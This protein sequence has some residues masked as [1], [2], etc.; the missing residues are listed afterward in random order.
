MNFFKLRV[1]TLCLSFSVLFCGVGQAFLRVGTAKDIITP[2]SLD[3]K[4]VGVFGE[5]MVEV[6]K[7]LYARVLVLDDGNSKLV[8][9]TY[10]LNCLDVATPILRSRLKHELG[11]S[12]EYFIPLATHNHCAPIQIVPENFEYG[13][14]LANKIFDLV[15]RA[16]ENLTGPVHLEF[17]NGYVYHLLS[18]GNAPVDYEVQVLKVVDSAGKVYAILF[19][20]PTHPLQ[21]AG[22]DNV[23]HP[24][25]PGYAM[26]FVEKAFDGCI[27]MYADAC[28][29]NQFTKSFMHADE[30][31]VI[32][33]AEE[34]SR[35]VIRVANEKKTPIEGKISS[36]FKVVSLSLA[37]PMPREQ[38]E[39]LALFHPMDIGFVPYPDHRRSSNWIR[40]LL[41]HYREGIPFPNKSSDKICTD[42]GFL[43][44]E[45]P[46]GRE[47]P[48]R[49]EESIVAKIGNFILVALQG[50]V[51][52][53]IGMR[54][55]DAF[56]YN[57]PIMVFGYMGEHNLYIPTREI[58]RLGLYQ[59][60]VIQE[61][62]ASPVGWAPTVEDE[63]VSAVREQISE[64]IRVSE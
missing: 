39:K 34:L 17:G 4:P 38:A 22:K 28:G 19:N 35:E 33:Y 14:W 52:A 5:R 46:D 47:Y 41:K 55:K 43:I 37:K 23:I 60:K 18:V 48:C 8:I 63:M 3:N 51:C 1:F 27:A 11:I 6:A 15:K 53:P 61:Q 44:E 30:A 16:L 10:D 56:R 58:V 32:K 9:V 36:S 40:S 62:Y 26:D 12:H 24:G 54:I 31:V 13:R 2:P 7:D 21:L 29:G 64:I 42:D 45:N 20:H 49:Y 57:Y 59:A 25:H 50:E